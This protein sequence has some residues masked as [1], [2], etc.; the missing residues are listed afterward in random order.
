[1]RDSYLCLAKILTSFIKNKE[2][3]KKKLKR[4]KAQKKKYFKT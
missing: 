3:K 1:L 2:N 4:K